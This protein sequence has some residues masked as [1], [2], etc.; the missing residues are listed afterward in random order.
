[1]ISIKLDPVP[2]P[3]MSGSDRWKHRPIVDRYFRFKDAL[4]ALCN[5]SNFELGDSYKVEFLIAMPKS[6]NAKKKNTYQGTPHRQR[7][8]LDNLLKAINDCLLTEDS[9]VWSIEASK[10]WWDEG[11]III[12]NKV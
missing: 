10:I 3:R 6:W 4:V 11:R 7:P 5:L 8:D 2:K 12:Y 9:V 1:M